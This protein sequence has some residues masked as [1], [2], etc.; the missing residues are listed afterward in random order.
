MARPKTLKQLEAECAA[1]NAEHAIGTVVDYQEVRGRSETTLR[2]KTRSEAQVLSGHSAVVWLEN[3]SGC[4]MLS[5]C[6]PVD[7]EATA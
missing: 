3:K 7:E 6:T 1:W 5:H 4:V 2:T